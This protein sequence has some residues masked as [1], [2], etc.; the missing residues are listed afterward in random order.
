MTVQELIETLQAEN[1]ERRVFLAT[2]GEGNDYRPL[3]DIGPMY[4][5]GDKV[6][7]RDSEHRHN[8]EL[9]IVLW[10]GW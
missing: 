6:V 8:A 5:C 9:I 10:P 4:D 3:H 2:D 7:G 1:P